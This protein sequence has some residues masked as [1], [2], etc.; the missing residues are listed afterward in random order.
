MST[1]LYPEPAG[2]CELLGLQGGIGN[3]I[4][5][6]APISKH[7]SAHTKQQPPIATTKQQPP[8]ATTHRIASTNQHAPSYTLWTL[9]PARQ[10]ACIGRHRAERCVGKW[11]K[12]PS[13]AQVK[14]TMSWA[15]GTTRSHGKM[16]GD[17]TVLKARSGQPTSGHNEN[18]QAKQSAAH[19]VGDVC[20]VCGGMCV[21]CV[22]CVCGVVFGV[23]CV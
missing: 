3:G 5:L 8:I 16:S 9:G 7:Q 22:R 14:S 10:T 15:D 1:S 13:Q 6:Q 12:S 11:S 21:R 2:P 20:G 18:G 17:C 4:G 23:W 19:G